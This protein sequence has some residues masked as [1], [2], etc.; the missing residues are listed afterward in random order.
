MGPKKYGILHEHW[1][2][3]A[4][5]GLDNGAHKFEHVCIVHT[6]NLRAQGARKEHVRRR[7]LLLLLLRLRLRLPLLVLQSGLEASTGFPFTALCY[8]KAMKCAPQF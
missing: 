2:G 6:S 7:S 1:C 5:A 8:F 4:G 3:E